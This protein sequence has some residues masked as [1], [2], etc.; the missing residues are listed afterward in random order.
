[1]KYCCPTEV[2]LQ[3]LFKVTENLVQENILWLSKAAYAGL[4]FSLFELYLDVLSDFY[5]FC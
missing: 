1:M 3:P 4:I 2:K 5:L